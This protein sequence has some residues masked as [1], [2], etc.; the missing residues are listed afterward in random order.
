MRR[1]KQKARF[2]EIDYVEEPD[3]VMEVNVPDG[4]G[5]IIPVEVGYGYRNGKKGTRYI[6]HND[7]RSRHYLAIAESCDT[8]WFRRRHKSEDWNPDAKPASS[9]RPPAV[10]SR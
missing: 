9:Y 5:R 1:K 2:E 6:F 10:P 8:R 7:P 4:E 3:F